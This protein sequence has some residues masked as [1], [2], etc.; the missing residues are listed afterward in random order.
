MRNARRDQ[1]DHITLDIQTTGDT[2]TIDANKRDDAWRDHNNDN[3]VETTFDI[4]VPAA[5]MLDIYGFSSDL[6]IRGITGAETLETFS[7]DITVDGAKSPIHAKTFSG[8]INARL[9]S[10]ASGEVS[11]DSFSGAFDSDIP[12]T[13]SVGTSG[14]PGTSGTR[15]CDLRHLRFQ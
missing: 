10:S 1:L 5:A 6:D 11:F 7:G 14:T 8:R 15:N 13:V 9:D 12:L 3:V 2:I 4:Q